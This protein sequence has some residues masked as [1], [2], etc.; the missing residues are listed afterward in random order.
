MENRMTEKQWKLL[1][2][3]SKERYAPTLLAQYKQFLATDLSKQTASKLIEQF[4]EAPKKSQ[5]PEYKAE[6][7]KA[8]KAEAEAI[9][10][11]ALGDA[12]IANISGSKAYSLVSGSNRHADLTKLQ[13]EFPQAYEAVVKTTAYDYIKA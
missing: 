2:K 3:L 6:Q 9:L 5:S 8:D 13:A 1:G 11:E 4:L 7:A 10:R 12:Q